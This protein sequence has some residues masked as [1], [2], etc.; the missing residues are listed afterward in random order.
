MRTYLL[1]TVFVIGCSS[2]ADKP[3]TSIKPVSE[4]P[5]KTT[6]SALSAFY[7][8]V[9][10]FPLVPKLLLPFV[11]RRSRLRYFMNMHAL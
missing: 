4:P 2:P 1:T 5:E 6:T 3:G 8:R 7:Y 11:L 9:G 10:P